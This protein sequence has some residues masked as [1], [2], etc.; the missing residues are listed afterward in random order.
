M[1]KLTRA[2][3]ERADELRAQLEVI[4]KK[5][6]AI[7]GNRGL[8][9]DLEHE[10]EEYCDDLSYY[11]NKIQELQE[12]IKEAEKEIVLTKRAIAKTRKSL[13]KVKATQKTKKRKP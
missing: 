1:S 13:A 3:Q 9:L 11:K 4:Q 8:I 2:Q 10:L 12:D 7:D 5:L 6:D